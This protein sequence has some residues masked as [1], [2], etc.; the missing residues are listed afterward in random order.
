[1]AFAYSFN[2]NSRAILHN[3]NQ[4]AGTDDP[5]LGAASQVITEIINTFADGTFLLVEVHGERASGAGSATSPEAA[6]L[7]VRVTPIVLSP[8]TVLVTQADD[9]LKAAHAKADADAKA[10]QDR[11]DA[12]AKAQAADTL[13]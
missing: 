6:T 12:D 5:V 9:A 10:A 1:M 3:L 11:I 8:G 13:S 2:G 7:N 4:K